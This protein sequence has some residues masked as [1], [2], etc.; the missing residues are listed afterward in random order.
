MF[1]GWRPI[2]LFLLVAGSIFSLY[3]LWRRQQARWSAPYDGGA[4]QG[5]SPLKGLGGWLIVV[6]IGQ[7]TALIQVPLMIFESVDLYRSEGNEIVRLFLGVDAALKVAVLALV[8][9]TTVAMFRRRRIFPLLWR[10]EAA[11]L[12]LFVFVEAAILATLVGLP[13]GDLLTENM[14]R[15]SLIAAIWAVPWV[16]YLAFS[17]RVRNTFVN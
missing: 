4:G 17:V 15:G 13:I 8:I 12:V 5:D 14:M 2:V 10:I 11:A 3:W 16:V 7:V 1:T 6:V 9:W